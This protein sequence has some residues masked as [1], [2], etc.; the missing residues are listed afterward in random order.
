MTTVPVFCDVDLFVNLSELE[1]CLG[2]LGLERPTAPMRLWLS[3][4]TD[5]LN[6]DGT[7]GYD[8]PSFLFEFELRAAAV[9]V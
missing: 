1:V 8:R 9:G 6:W 3:L 4:T 2:A 5:L 7:I